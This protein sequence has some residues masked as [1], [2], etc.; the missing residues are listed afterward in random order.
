MKVI[1]KFIRF[2]HLTHRARLLLLGNKN[3]AKVLKTNSIRI[4]NWR[5]AKK[6]YLYLP[7]MRTTFYTDA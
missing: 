1:P 7:E 2:F 3:V 6:P 4:S 5:R